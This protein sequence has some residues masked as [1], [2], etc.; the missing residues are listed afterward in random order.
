MHPL[1]A[2]SES[3]D[4]YDEPLPAR[5][6]VMQSWVR[7]ALIVIALGLLAVFAI[8][9]S[10]DPYRGGAVWT[11]GT[12]RQLGLPPCS[13]V[14]LTGLPCPSCGMTTSFALLMHGDVWN[15]I[16]ANW[17]GTLLALAG[18]LYIPWAI[19]SAV[20]GRPLWVTSIE[21]TLCRLVTIFMSLMLLRWFAVLLLHYWS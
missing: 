18:L 5:V 4:L 21:G 12:H 14:V 3:P 6:P 2:T 1:S 9:I 10:L 13:L 19:Y 20:R 17:V 7:L 11:Q 15:S 16:Q 8:A